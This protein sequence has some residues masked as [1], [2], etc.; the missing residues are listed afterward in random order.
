MPNVR[1]FISKLKQKPLSITEAKL[2]LPYAYKKRS[3][4]YFSGGFPVGKIA[5]KTV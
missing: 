1:Q 4:Y 2:I 3:K 5:K